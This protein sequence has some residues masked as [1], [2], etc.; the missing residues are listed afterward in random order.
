MNDLKIIFTGPMG[1]GK[2]TAIAAISEIPP[3]STDVENTERHISDKDTT[4]VALDYGQITLVDGKILRLY[5]TPGQQRFSYMWEIL[6]EGALGVIV[7][8]DASQP[9]VVEQL[10]DYLDIFLNIKSAPQVLVSV[11][12]HEIGGAKINRALREVI[13]RRGVNIP[14]ITSDVRNR[15]DV[16]IM[17][18]LLVSMLEAE[19]N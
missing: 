9:T 11:G 1:A 14:L 5:G 6:A 18:D 4:T 15:E 13:S 10:D 19:T 16:I 7:L 3:V 8:L 17:I 2:T 12:R